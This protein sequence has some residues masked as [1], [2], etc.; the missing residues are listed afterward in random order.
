MRIT[1]NGKH[2]ETEGVSTLEE[3]I[4][5]HARDLRHVIAEVNGEVVKNPS[6]RQRLLKN[7][8]VI[9]LVN[10]VGGG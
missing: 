5:Q 7:N 8:D 10:F 1:L 9:E 2:L 6:W 3:L 4:I